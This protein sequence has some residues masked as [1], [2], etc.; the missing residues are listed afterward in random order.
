M[1]TLGLLSLH[2]LLTPTWL[3][4]PMSGPPASFVGAPFST[5]FCLLQSSIMS[6]LTHSYHRICA[7]SRESVQLLSTVLDC[8]ETMNSTACKNSSAVRKIREHVI[9]LWRCLSMFAT[10]LMRRS[11]IKP[12]HQDTF[13]K[14]T[15][16][17]PALPWHPIAWAVRTSS[18]L[19]FRLSFRRQLSVSK[20]LVSLSIFPSYRRLLHPQGRAVDV[21][22]LSCSSA[23]RLSL[24]SC[25]VRGQ[26]NLQM[27]P[28]SNTSAASP[29]VQHSPDETA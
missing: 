2:I 23:W 8:E 11:L 17:H 6:A 19:E 5:G 25:V 4:E 14:A 15:S 20:Q 3:P 28:R 18:A 24:C 7:A 9:S 13:S 1:A 10:S 26:M 12:S 27:K 21:S 16:A 22:Y 29:R